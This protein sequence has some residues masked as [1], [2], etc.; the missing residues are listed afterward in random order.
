MKDI[1]PQKKEAVFIL[2]FLFCVLICGL[3]AG[4]GLANAKQFKNVVSSQKEISIETW[5]GTASTIES[6]FKENVAGRNQLIDI[7]GVSLRMIQKNLVG[8]FEFLRDSDGIMQ[9]FEER[10]QP[11]E[12]ISSMV[13]LERR[14]DRDDIPLVFLQYPDRTENVPLA[15]QLDFNTQTDEAILDTLRDSGV[16]IL[17]FGERMKQDNSAPDKSEFFFHTDVHFS[18]EGEF[19]IVKSAAEYLIKEYKMRLTEFDRVFDISQYDV[20]SYDFLGNSAR[21]A[22]KYFV[23]T[24][25]FN[26]Y[27]PKFETNLLLID[28]DGKQTRNGLFETVAMNG[29]E[30]RDDITLYTYWVTNYGHY[31]EPRYEYQNNLNPFGPKLLVITDSSLLRGTAFLSLACSKVT[32]VDTRFMKGIP[33]IEQALN[34]ELYDAVIVGGFSKAFLSSGFSVNTVMPGLPERPAQIADY[35][36]AT[37]GICLDTY[38]GIRLENAGKFAVSLESPVVELVGWAADFGAQKPLKELYLQIGDINIKCN[39]GIERT[40]V[41]SHFKNENLKNTGFSVT[42]PASYL[43]NGQI[44][45]LRFIQVGADGTYRYEPITYQL[46]YS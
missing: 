5:P 27:I 29:Y 42:F 34:E 31:P 32:V 10:A 12:F 44:N 22:G 46:L 43:Q 36:I 15:A 40:S 20:H 16:D 33:Y 35:W 13:D 45:E 19:W 28:K 21:S 37:N 23:G 18:T 25:C 8:N 9:R 17:N 14:L 26:C 39:Y 2:N 6:Q 4:Y 38:N 24:D 41:S 7:Y 11:G 1:F 3:F 30:Q